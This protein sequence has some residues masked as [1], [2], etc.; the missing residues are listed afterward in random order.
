[1]D[2]RSMVSV[3]DM[4]ELFVSFD[5]KYLWVELCLVPINFTD[6][7][8]FHSHCFVMS[9]ISL[10][11]VTFKICVMVCEVNETTWH[12]LHLR[13]SITNCKNGAT[14]QKV[15]WSV[16]LWL[17][18]YVSSPPAWKC[19]TPDFFKSVSPWNFAIVMSALFI[20]QKFLFT[21]V[22]TMIN[23]TWNWNLN[24]FHA[25]VLLIT[26]MLHCNTVD[27]P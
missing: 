23:K 11:S 18:D 20:Y 17:K 24:D 5:S 6:P 16:I 10:F 1:L 14:N 15:H 7:K 13:L 3:D 22:A 26:L 19:W 9:I 2:Y 4:P 12:I 21:C 27:S 8:Q 25:A